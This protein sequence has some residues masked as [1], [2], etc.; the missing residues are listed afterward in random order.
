MCFAVNNLL[1]PYRYHVSTFNNI[2][3]GTFLTQIFLQNALRKNFQE[4]QMQQRINSIISQANASV[5]DKI[6]SEKKL[7]DIFGSFGNLEISAPSTV[8]FEEFNNETFLKL[9]YYIVNT[10]NF[11][12]GVVIVKGVENEIPS[13]RLLDPFGK[14]WFCGRGNSKNDDSNQFKNT[15]EIV[16]ADF[17][18]IKK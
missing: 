16:E 15:E 14:I 13:V 5:K 1:F 8:S 3:P 4:V 18:E 17:R 9:E 7:R 10:S 2:N 12:K 11:N 6:S